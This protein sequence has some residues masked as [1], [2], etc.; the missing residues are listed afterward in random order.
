[1]FKAEDLIQ[2]WNHHIQ[3]APA[4][5]VKVSFFVENPVQCTNM[6]KVINS[7]LVI[8]EEKKYFTG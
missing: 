2:S 1:M 3:R 4:V 8:D 5:A 7:T 6:K